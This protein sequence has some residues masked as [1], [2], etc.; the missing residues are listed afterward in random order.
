MAQH[1][2]ELTDRAFGVIAV[3]GRSRSVLRRLFGSGLAPLAAALLPRS[4]ARARL[5]GYLGQT[6][7]RYPM[8]DSDDPVVG[9]RLPPVGDNHDLLRSFGWQLHRY[10]SGGGGAGPELPPWVEGPYDLPADASGRLRH[11]RSYLIRPDGFVAASAPV[12]DPADL[13]RALAVHGLA[14]GR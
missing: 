11:D 3:R 5:G 4:S 14:G 2:V 6:R 7:I 1:L 8:I 12:D 13:H 9:R 10:R